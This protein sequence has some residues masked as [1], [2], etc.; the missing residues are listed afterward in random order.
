MEAIL[1]EMKD[2][3]D[4]IDYWIN[5]LAGLE[6]KK[7]QLIIKSTG[8]INRNALLLCDPTINLD[9]FDFEEDI[10]DQTQEILLQIKKCRDQIGE[11]TNKQRGLIHIA[12][13][14][15]KELQN[16]DKKERANS[17]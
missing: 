7:R 16:A 5:E 14:L 13:R 15:R 17:V 8:I 4:T 3:N 9:Q 12:C 6:H 2:V 10:H 11:T 1:A